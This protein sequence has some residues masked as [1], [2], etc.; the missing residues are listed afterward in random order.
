MTDGQE[1]AGVNAAYDVV[2]PDQCA[3]DEMDVGAGMKLGF[4][5]PLLIGWP[6]GEPINSLNLMLC[7]GT[8]SDA[9]AAVYVL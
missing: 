3:G 2:G 5:G 4:S 8:A 7:S 9:T 6:A 1:A